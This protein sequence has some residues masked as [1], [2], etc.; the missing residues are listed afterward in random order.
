MN[1]WQEYGETLWGNG[2]TIVPIYA[3]DA[4]KKG[5]GKRPI[6]KDWERTINDKEQIQRWAERYTKNGIGIL[7]KNTPAVDIDVYDK[8]A[9]EH[10]ADWLVK[11]VGRA[12]CRIG[13]EPKKLFLF[14]TES[15]FSKVKSGVWEDDFGQLHAVEV[16]ADG[17]QF[18]AYGIHPDTRKDYYWIDGEDPLNNA[19]DFDLEEIS[20]D[21]ARSIAAE[22]DRYAAEQG[23]TR[24][25]RPMNGY[26]AVG[27]ADDD[28]WAANADVRKWDGSYEELHDLVMK[29][30]N[31]EDY[32]NY[33]KVLAALQIS[34]RDQAEAKAIARDWAMQANNFDSDDFEYKWD[35]GFSHGATRL[36]TIGSI[37]KEVKDKEDEEAEQKATD[38]KEAFDACSDLQEWKNW[39]A[40]FKKVPIFGFTRKEVVN[41]AAKSYYRITGER[42][43]AED[44]KTELR[45]DHSSRTMPN[46]LRNY[47]FSEANDVFIRKSTG[48]YIS[49]SAF[50]TA[51]AT[52][53]NFDGESFKPSEY[54][55]KINPVP[56]IHDSMYY[57]AMHGD[58]DESLWRNLPGSYGTD[59]FFDDAGRQWFNS[60]DPDSIPKASE[61]LST[62]D[63][64]AIEIIKDF[65]VVLFPND[66]ERRYVMDWMAWVIQHPTKRINYSLLIRGAH[67]SGK[68]TLGI[69]MSRMLGQRNVGY[70]SNTVMNGRFSDWAEGDI[71]KIVEEVYDKGDRY[72]AIER[73]KEYITNDRFQVEPKGR[74]P[75]VVMNTSSKMMFTNH[76]NALPLDENQ[77]RYLVVS[78]QAENH[79]DMERVYG[80]KVERSRFFKNVYRAIDNH[81]PAI[82]KWFMDW[83][84][85]DQFDHKGHA[86]QDTEAFEIMAD[87]S[88]DGIQG[89]IVQ[90]LR[91]GDTRGV[92]QDV[93]FT[94]DLKNALLESDDIEFPKSNRLKNMLMELGFKPGGLIKL[95]GT[96]GRVYVRKRVKGAFD[97]NGKLN[98]DWARKTLK[99]HN[100]NVEK[101]S[102]KPSD[103]FDDEDEV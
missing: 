46:W 74:K 1:Y 2:Y 24:V 12:P 85:S 15:P 70:V 96:T 83:E 60:F 54:A 62:Y 45:F 68:T 3:P 78:T 33:I 6:G 75:K 98:A 82:K 51:N 63:K 32:E 92:N 16:L 52:L 100:D 26:E 103:H 102:K 37:I 64:K 56:M 4:D 81:V 35:K 10:M 11:N 57:P 53:C 90:M 97:E 61:S 8:D 36:V 49:K 7:T 47:V 72:S 39:A 89:V 28:D 101:I 5:A 29:Y 50:D 71:L 17:Q 14:R 84:I 94:N 9:A 80:S 13:R 55:S 40:D 34:C 65:F 21:T 58:M 25:K 31:P 20:I 69:L 93:I 66:K 86:P 59:F 30:P 95:E 73:Q 87:A 41:V 19:A 88:N 99:K 42:L 18:V 91:A 27:S 44:K 22:F 38:F 43:T 77:R 48:D 67:G 79:L 23:W 76:F